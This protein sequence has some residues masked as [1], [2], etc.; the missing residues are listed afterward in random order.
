MNLLFHLTFFI[1]TW[2][3]IPAPAIAQQYKK[4]LLVIHSYSAE[5]HWIK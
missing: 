1:I 5:S 3:L 4:N 2:G